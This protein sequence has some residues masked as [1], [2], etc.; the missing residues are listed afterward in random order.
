MCLFVSEVS[1]NDFNDGNDAETTDSVTTGEFLD[2]SASLGNLY[3]LNLMLEMNQ[4]LNL[5]RKSRKKIYRLKVSNRNTGTRCEI[6]Q[7]RRSGVSIVNFK[8]IS[9]FILVFSIVNFEHVIAGS[10][11]STIID[12]LFKSFDA[13][14]QNQSV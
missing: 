5:C 13:Q 7:W 14:I 4:L 6:C 1:E 2:N 12:C 9:H 11:N 3:M 10:G 8:Y